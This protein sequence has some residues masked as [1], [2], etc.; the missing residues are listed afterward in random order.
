MQ[1]FHFFSAM[2]ERFFPESSR[3]PVNPTENRFEKKL[4]KPLKS[5]PSSSGF[6][7]CRQIYKQPNQNLAKTKDLAE[8][9][10]GKGKREEREGQG[11]R[12]VCLQWGGMDMA[13]FEYMVSG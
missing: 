5:P 2:F 10:E 1:T 9:L 8:I 11:E 3:C 4:I 6:Y 13:E 7:S 12:W